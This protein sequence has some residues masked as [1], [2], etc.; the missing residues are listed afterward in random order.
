MHRE[1]HQ[2]I[3]AHPFL[4]F[5]QFISLVW[6]ACSWAAT[7]AL[8]WKTVSIWHWSL[9]TSLAKASAQSWRC[10]R[11]K[12]KATSRCVWGV[13]GIVA[14]KQ[15]CVSDVVFVSLFLCL[16]PPL[17]RCGSACGSVLVSICL[18]MCPYCCLCI[19]LSCLLCICVS[20]FICLRVSACSSVY[21]LSSPL[22]L[23]IPSPFSHVVLISVAA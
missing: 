1:H 10:S 5:F 2:V 8:R 12:L 21:D 19:C 4:F 13:G 6:L 23:C 18:Y 9:A 20:F 16:S 17:F 22:L 11:G 3:F 14:W 7:L 15:G